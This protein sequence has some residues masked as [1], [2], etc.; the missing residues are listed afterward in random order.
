M[1][2]WSTHVVPAAL[3]C[4]ILLATLLHA[5]KPRKG[6]PE[7]KAA[8]QASRATVLRTANVYVAA[9]DN[10]L[11]TSVITPGHEL[12]IVERSGDWV[13]VFANT[14]VND[15]QHS[16]DE[17]DFKDPDENVA[18]T[19]G[20]IHNKGIVG[21]PTPGGDEILYG[22]AA[23]LE[24][25]AAQPHAPKDAPFD[26]TLLY[27]RVFEYYPD[28]PLAP[29]AMWRSAD[30]RWQLEKRDIST[31]P[32]AKEQE[33]YLRPQLYEGDLRRVMKLY[34]GTREAALAAYDLLDNKLCG[35]WQGLPHCPDM[36]AGLYL[37]YAGQF[38]DGPKSA[39]ALYN[40]VYREAVLVTMYNVQE[41]Q[42]RA[43]QAVA[44][45]GQMAADLEQQYPKSDFAPR[46]ASLAYK[47][48]QGIAVY[49]NER[50]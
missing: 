8:A 38:P 35:D 13:K 46:A 42:K 37:R 44:R 36:E 10:S 7:E 15:E 40:A 49:G 16:T 20:W 27:R 31:L 32:S 29:E 39:E 18:P 43:A 30:I 19:S 12:A 26:A 48:K 25:E 4:L 5:Q 9:D 33:A 22:T 14:D 45:T 23:N 34:P 6:T 2:V 3:A 47:V 21:P 28:S 17:P 1:R 11:H 24:D 41:D 50:D